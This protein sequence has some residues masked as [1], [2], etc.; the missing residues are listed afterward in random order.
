M[1]SEKYERAKNLISIF[2]GHTPLYVFFD[3]DKKLMLAPRTM[4]VDINEVLI[5]E[6]KRELGEK[7]VVFKT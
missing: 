7:N 1:N 3:E 5:R 4:W 2:D 6:L